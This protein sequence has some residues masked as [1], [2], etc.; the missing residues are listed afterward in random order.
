[1]ARILFVEDEEHN[2]QS[3]IWELEDAEHE[4]IVVGEAEE[5]IRRLDGGSDFDLIILDI[6]LPRGNDQGSPAVGDDIKTGKMGLEILRQLREEMKLETPVVVLT[7]VLDD[8]P[9]TELMN[10]GAARY[11]VKPASLEEFMEAVDAMLP[12]G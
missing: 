3:F 12:P 2:M 4:V 7:A 8:E 6:M 9:K 1:M 10:L 11:L 5:T